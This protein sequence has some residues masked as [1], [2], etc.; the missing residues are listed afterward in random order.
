MDGYAR[1]R[2]ALIHKQVTGNRKFF[3]MGEKDDALALFQS[4]P[5]WWSAS[6]HAHMSLI[7]KAEESLIKERHGHA[8]SKRSA[9]T[10]LPRRFRELSCAVRN[11]V[12]LDRC[13][14]VTT[15]AHSRTCKVKSPTRK[16]DAIND[17]QFHSSP[18]KRLN[19]HRSTAG[20]RQRISREAVRRPGSQSVAEAVIAAPADDEE[21][22]KHH[23]WEKA[24]ERQ[25]LPQ[26]QAE[27]RRQH[28]FVSRRYP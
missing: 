4:R 26:C 28:T 27:D 11:S 3:V 8:R 6:G 23:V 5:F 25:K 17:H 14:D 18:K 2:R 7:E 19:H 10:A 22:D 9:R 12:L 1:R 21:H 20:R 16:T 24:A 15:S 13:L